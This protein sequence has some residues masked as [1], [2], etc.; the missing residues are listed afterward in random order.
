MSFTHLHIHSVHSLYHST[1][2]VK[3]AVDKAVCLGMNALAIT[4]YD[5]YM[6]HMASSVILTK[7]I[8]RLSP[9]PAVNCM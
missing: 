6:R 3:D 9:L 7:L 4:D 1:L 2:T 8:R 5:S